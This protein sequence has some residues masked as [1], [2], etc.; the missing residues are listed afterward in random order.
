MHLVLQEL[1]TSCCCLCD[2]DTFK[3]SHWLRENAKLLS[4]SNKVI[5]QVST[6]FSYRVASEALFAVT[7]DRC[8]RANAPA[9]CLLR[10]AYQSEQT[11]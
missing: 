5:L 10:S 8:L 11:L 7:G 2:N 4:K 9:G 1:E 3:Y 6:Q